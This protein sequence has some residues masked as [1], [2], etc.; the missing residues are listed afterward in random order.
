MFMVCRTEVKTS[1][2]YTAFRC[3]KLL[4]C[5]EKLCWLV[6]NQKQAGVVILRRPPFLVQ[7]FAILAPL[8]GALILIGL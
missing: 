3:G 4:S 1:R 6:S 5:C 2:P 7:S 8:G